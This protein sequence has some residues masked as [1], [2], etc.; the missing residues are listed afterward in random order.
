MGK[1]KIVGGFFN[2][3]FFFTVFDGGFG[4]WNGIFDVFLRFS[5]TCRRR[6]GV[7]PTQYGAGVGRA[8]DGNG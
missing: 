3:Q 4:K 5:P 6:R 8:D 7:G 2:L 1:G